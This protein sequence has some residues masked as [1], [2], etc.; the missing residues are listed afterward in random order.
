MKAPLAG[1]I[2]TR[3]GMPAGQLRAELDWLI[4]IFKREG[5]RS[6]LEIGARSGDTFWEVVSSLPIGAKAVAVDMPGEA[7]GLKDTDPHLFNRIKELRA[8]R[9][10]ALAFIGNSHD[11]VIRTFVEEQAPFDAVLIDGDH[12]LSG[13]TQDWQDYGPMGR[14]IAFHDIAWKRDIFP[15]QRIEVPQFW[16]SVKSK[17]RSEEIRSATHDCGIGMLWRQ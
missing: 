11:P 12:T 14:L 15:G 8:A 2:E 5:V 7:W 10:N 4:A 9:Y 3:S 6:Y 16:A 17:Y 1:L 13:V